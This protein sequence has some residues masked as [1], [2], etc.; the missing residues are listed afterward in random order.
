VESS[1]KFIKDLTRLIGQFSQTAAQFIEQFSR[2]A[3]SIHEMLEAA[4]DNQQWWKQGIAPDADGVYPDGVLNQR[5]NQEE[6][7]P[8][9]LSA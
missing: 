1:E 5:W 3:A 4:H 9:D 7:P 6:P 2:L 8:Y